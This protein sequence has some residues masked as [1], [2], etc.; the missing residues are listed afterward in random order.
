[1]VKEIRDDVT[2]APITNELR[3]TA[4]LEEWFENHSENWILG[5]GKG[6]IGS[7]RAVESF[8]VNERRN[9]DSE[10]FPL[11]GVYK[12]GLPV[13]YCTLESLGDD[14][15]TVNLFIYLSPRS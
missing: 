12:E 3:E 2:V 15:R 1:M 7:V 6:D 9:E 10:S 13:G 14:Y 11:L 5:F 8:K 4:I